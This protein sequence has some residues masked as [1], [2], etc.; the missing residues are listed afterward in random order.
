MSVEH[1]ARQHATHRKKAR[2]VNALIIINAI[3]FVITIFLNTQYG[4]DLYKSLGLHHPKSGI[5]LFLIFLCMAAIF[6][7]LSI[8]L[9]FGCLVPCWK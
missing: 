2:T 4:V 8:C 5:S 7:F 1:E 3:L 6:I 9:C